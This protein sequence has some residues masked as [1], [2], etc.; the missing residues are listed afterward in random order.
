MHT[1]YSTSFSLLATNINFARQTAST[2]SFEVTPTS[3]S[4]SGS[5][6]SD[7]AIGIGVIVGGVVV[8]ATIIGILWWFCCHRRDSWWKKRRAK[9]KPVPSPPNAS[10]GLAQFPTQSSTSG[11]Y[12]NPSYATESYAN[13][14]YGN[15]SYTTPSYGN[16]NY[17]N[18]AYTNESYNLN[19]ASQ[20]YPMQPVRPMP[21]SAPLSVNTQ[22]LQQQSAP[23]RPPSTPA[24]LAWKQSEPG[25]R[26]MTYKVEFIPNYIPLE[27]VTELFSFVDSKRVAVRS[28]A[29]SIGG[30][31][32]GSRTATV[33][34]SSLVRN[35]KGPDLSSEAAAMNVTVDRRFQGWTPLN[36]PAAAAN[37]E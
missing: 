34:F 4:T 30:M 25:S 19:D 28:Y 16:Q 35:S 32:R 24:S 7:L 13:P 14:N 20:I 6:S 18:T 1:C 2:L 27:K 5:D 36:Y 10:N 23:Q 29:P 22:S 9:Y 17:Q 37:A 21:S 12:V 3:S 8:L 15:Q 11:G 33:E 31:G 26:T